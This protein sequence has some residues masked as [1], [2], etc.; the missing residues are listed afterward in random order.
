MKSQTLSSGS[1]RAAGARITIRETSCSSTGI[2]IHT[3]LTD[4]RVFNCHHV[5]MSKRPHLRKTVIRVVLSFVPAL[6][7]ELE[8]NPQKERRR[9]TPKRSKKKIAQNL[10]GQ[11]NCRQTVISL[12]CH[13]HSYIYWVPPSQLTT[14]SAP[15]FN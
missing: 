12:N 4:C 1:T 8:H 10:T 14:E 6:K 15:D 5:W 11:E 2:Q 7:P 13:V 3:R 9:K